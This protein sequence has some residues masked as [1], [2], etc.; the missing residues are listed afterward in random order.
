MVYGRSI[1]VDASGSNVSNSTDAVREEVL[2]GSATGH[3]GDSGER[4]GRGGAILRL[5]CD[6]A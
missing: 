3:S 6:F 2:A 1:V 4:G 5:S